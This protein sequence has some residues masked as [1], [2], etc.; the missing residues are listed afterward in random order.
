[1]AIWLAAGHGFINYMNSNETCLSRMLNRSDSINH[2][3]LNFFAIAGM[4]FVKSSLN[5]QFSHLC[6]LK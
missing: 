4:L 3:S 1:M 2:I 5:V 6:T